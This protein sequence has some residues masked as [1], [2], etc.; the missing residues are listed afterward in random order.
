MS[1]QNPKSLG[2][3]TVGNPMEFRVVFKR[4]GAPVDPAT[5]AVEIVAPADEATTYTYGVGA[6]VTKLATGVYDVSIPSPEAA[7]W[8]AY[9]N[10]HDP[11]RAV[12]LTWTVDAK[13]S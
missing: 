2:R 6:V 8:K 11:D 9:V 10:S 7:T 13:I 12:N 1:P 3:V 4:H 5:V